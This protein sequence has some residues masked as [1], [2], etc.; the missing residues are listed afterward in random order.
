MFFA[1]IN[2]AITKL[3]PEDEYS[4]NQLEAGSRTIYGSV[5]SYHTKIWSQRP[6]SLLTAPAKLKATNY[7]GQTA[8]ELNKKRALRHVMM[9]SRAFIEADYTLAAREDLRNDLAKAG[10]LQAYEEMKKPKWAYNNIRKDNL[11]IADVF[12]FVGLCLGEALES[13]SLDHFK[14]RRE[15]LIQTLID[16][17]QNNIRLEE[18]VLIRLFPSVQS[19]KDKPYRRQIT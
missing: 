1:V 19:F 13:T 2:L 5:K 16:M 11:F 6:L 3:D 12:K 4:I 18:D 8:A 14:I 10:I 9:L 7:S 17:L 15:L